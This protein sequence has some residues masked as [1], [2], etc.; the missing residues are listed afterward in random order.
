MNTELFLEVCNVR[1]QPRYMHKAA[2]IRRTFEDIGRRLFK[3]SLCIYHALFIV[4]AVL[5]H[6]RLNEKS[7]SQ[8]SRNSD[9]C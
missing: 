9:L 5:I 3:S 6:R 7:L 2:E 1:R 4:R 8:R